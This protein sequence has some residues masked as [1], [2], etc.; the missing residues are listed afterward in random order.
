VKE[1]IMLGAIAGDICGAPWE[2]GSCPKEHLELFG[3]ETGFTDDT[4]CTLAI[5][6]AL[7]EGKDPAATLRAWASRYPG[8]GYGASFHRW[9]HS[10]SGP[11]GSASNGSCMRVS[12]IGMLAGSLEQSDA[13]A[14]ASAVVTHNHIDAVRGA[15]AI[16]G[17]MFLAR[18]GANPEQMRQVLSARY[19]YDL[20][21]SVDDLIADYRFSTLAAET[22]PRAI[23]CALEAS[24]WEEAVSNAIAVGGD[25]DTLACM[26]GGIAEARFGMPPAHAQKALSYLSED[27]VEVL[28]AVYEQAGRAKP[29]EAE[30]QV[31]L[32]H[33]EVAQ[34]PTRHR[35]LAWFQQLFA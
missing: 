14:E 22:A 8:V 34:V 33:D 7:L 35:I 21:A 1:T 32:K 13:W 23:I 4:V 6:Q 19:G 29:W 30:E 16:A 20:S 5:A 2:G 11:Y 12:A 10:Q 24:S 9:A 28:A 18:A 26:A 27:M 17:A 15:C 3:L 31:A 25:T